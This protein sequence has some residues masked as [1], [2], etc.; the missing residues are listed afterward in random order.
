[1]NKIKNEKGVTL[2]ALVI[3]IIVMAIIAGIS[4][5][6]GVKMMDKEEATTIETNM[7]AIKA[8]AKEYSENVDAK[9][10][11]IKDADKKEEANKKEY[12]EKYFYTY[13]DSSTYSNSSSWYKDISNYTYYAL[14]QE[15]L[16]NMDLSDLWN[17]NVK[18]VVKC[19]K[20]DNNVDVIYV[21]GVEVN[22]T[23]YYELSELQKVL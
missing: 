21:D 5:T 10:W 23:I 17:G 1:M 2:L 3:T 7:Y 19:S 12:K 4:I 14:G 15:A 8:K 18:Y 6:Q 22:K 13:I 20:T 11:N 16:N 9:N